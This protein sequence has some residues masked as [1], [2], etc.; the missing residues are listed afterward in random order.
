MSP[1]VDFLQTMSQQLHWTDVV[2]IALVSFLIYRLMQLVRGGRAFQMVVGTLVLVGLFFA[3]RW[4]QLET[5]NWLLRN[6]LAYVGFA[7]IVLYQAELRR[8][9]AN[10]G[11]ARV[12]HYFPYLT[13]LGS[14]TTKSA[15][16]EIVFA[17]MALSRRRIGAIVVIERDI[18]LRSFI[19]GG[20]QIDAVVTY[21][22]LLT[23][24]N[25]KAPLHDGAVIVTGDRVAAAACF[26][27]ITINPQVSKELGTRHRAAIGVTEETD[28]IA[29]VVSEETSVVSW[30]DDGHM[31]ANLERETLRDKLH[32]AL[33]TS[34]SPSTDKDVKPVTREKT[35]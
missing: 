6:S 28:A 35:A 33:G 23:I 7:I 25:P 19:E 32:R 30:V 14:T 20:V 8:A 22:L 34:P 10:L 9:L 27:P 11:R 29:I 26:L 24:F 15:V 18:G 17:I 1:L 16:D 5:V 4:A 12:F 21:D 3:S 13:G 31:I 2:D